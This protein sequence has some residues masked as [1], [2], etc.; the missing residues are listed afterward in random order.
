MKENSSML[1]KEKSIRYSAQTITDADDANNIVLL[2]NIPSQPKSSLHSME[3]A[4]GD[5]GPHVNA[6]KI[7]Y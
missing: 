5:I 7:Q 4:A 6:D 2:A 3:Q 1:A